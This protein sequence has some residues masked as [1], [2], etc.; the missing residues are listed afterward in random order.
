MITSDRRYPAKLIDLP[1]NALRLLLPLSADPLI[2]GVE[3]TDHP[4]KWDGDEELV[5]GKAGQS[6]RPE[7][8]E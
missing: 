4:V 7:I 3:D 1:L 6:P 8:E 5:F 2:E